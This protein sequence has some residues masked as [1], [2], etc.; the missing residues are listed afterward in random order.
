M[1]NESRTDIYDFLYNLFYDVVTK[2]VYFMSEPQELTKSDTEDGFIVIRLGDIVDYSEFDM[3]SYGAVRCFVEAYVPTIT[4]GRL[5]FDK[6]KEFEDSI[7]EVIKTASET[8]D[9][10][11]SV[12]YGSVLSMEDVEDSNANSFFHMFIKSFLIQ[13]DTQK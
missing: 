1:Y 10:E 7:N 8:T 13:I 4:R 5:D 2:N 12:Q 9:G 6:Y 11:Y 3:E